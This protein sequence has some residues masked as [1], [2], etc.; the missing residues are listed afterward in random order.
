MKTRKGYIL[1]SLGKEFVLVAEGLDAVDF[2]R[3]VSLNESAAFL[4]K[5][6]EDKDFEAETLV[7]LLLDEYGITRDVAEKDVAALL[8]TWKETDM[9]IN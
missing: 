9:I 7:E 3:M 5:S 6:V 2:S 4:W 1:R 8:Q